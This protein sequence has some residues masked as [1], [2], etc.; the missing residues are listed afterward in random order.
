MTGFAG[1]P[2]TARKRKREDEEV[3]AAVA[4]A[5]QLDKVAQHSQNLEE[6]F[7]EQA[8]TDQQQ[9]ENQA[10]KK[11][12]PEDAEASTGPLGFLVGKALPPGLSAGKGPPGITSSSAANRAVPLGISVK[13]E[14]ASVMPVKQEAA[15]D[16][17]QEVKQEMLQ[18]L[19]AAKAGDSELMSRENSELALGVSSDHEAQVGSTQIH[20]CINCCMGC[21]GAHDCA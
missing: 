15:N 6:Q 13:Q 12:K 8:A 21:W 1:S 14:P 20:T 18:E 7:V 4:E 16:V 10:A 9:L 17:K 19:L 2:E 11:V 3:Q 5:E